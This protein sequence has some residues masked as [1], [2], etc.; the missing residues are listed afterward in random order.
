[1]LEITVR[2]THLDVMGHVNNA[3]YVEYLEWGRCDELEKRGIDLWQMLREGLGFVVVNLNVNFRREAFAGEI[4]V[5]ESGLKE[6]RNNK[7]GVLEQRIRRKSNDEVVC[8]AEVT[9]LVFDT[10]AHKSITMPENIRRMMLA[11]PT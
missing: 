8:D 10:K 3:Q 6:I 9:F 2:T 1:M 4:L 11:E 7:I 5:I